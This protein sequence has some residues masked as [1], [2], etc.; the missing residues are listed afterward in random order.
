MTSIRYAN[1]AYLIA[2]GTRAAFSRASEQLVREG[3]PPITVVSGDREFADQESLFRERYV[4]AGDIRGRRVHDIKR[5][6]GQLWYRVSS[7]GTVAVPGTSLHETRRA[8]DLG[9]PYNNRNTAAHRRLQQIAGSHGIVWTGR[10]FDE[11]W[12][13]EYHGELGS[14]EAPSSSTPV[15]NAPKQGEE[16]VQMFIVRRE[17]VNKLFLISDE[18]ITRLWDNSVA[19]V[20]NYLGVRG[21]NHQNQISKE[22]FRRI[23]EALGFKWD[24]VE[25]LGRG[26]RLLIDRSQRELRAGDVPWPA[27]W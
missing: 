18:G 8:A 5:W 12:H 25:R 19:L 24:E 4:R 1:D 26:R 23:I 7:D 9:Y 16:D 22:D 11:D 20:F 13:W 17:D 21:N 3:H 2:T 14:I 15:E 27:S 6:D 10:N